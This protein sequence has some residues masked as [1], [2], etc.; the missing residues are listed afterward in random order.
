MDPQIAAAGDTI[1][2][3]WTMPGSSVWGAGTLATAVSRDGGRTWTPAPNPADDASNDGHSFL[4]LA[5][6]ESGTFQAFWLDSRDGA[7]GLRAAFSADGGRTWSANTSIDT[8]TCECCWNKAVAFSPG[9][10]AVLYRD[11]GPRDMALAITTNGGRTWTRRT[12]VGRFGWNIE[13]CPHVG[14]G[15]AH[16]QARGAKRLHAVVWTGAEGQEGLHRLASQ[17]GGRTWSSPVRLGT[18]RA[19]HGDIAAS[20]ARLA[21]VWDDERNDRQVIMAATSDDNGARWSSP[22]QLS[23]STRTATHPLVIWSGERFVAFWTDAARDGPTAWR[24]KAISTAAVGV[25][26]DSSGAG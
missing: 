8:R 10:L 14:G 4:E 16:T 17:D 19:K 1:V 5:A 9:S 7:Q 25:K 22:I 12:T 21:A 20:G 3:L 18:A 26:G 6:D 24:T 11:K 15:L 23:D 13:A 2:V